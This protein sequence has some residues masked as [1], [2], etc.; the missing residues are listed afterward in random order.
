[1]KILGLGLLKCDGVSLYCIPAVKKILCLQVQ[2]LEHW[3]LRKL[4]NIQ[5]HN[6]TF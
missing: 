1:M 5:R 6:V 4:G 2:G 3:V